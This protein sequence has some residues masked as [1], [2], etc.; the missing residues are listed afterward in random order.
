MCNIK[1]PSR[2]GCRGGV[3]K[4]RVITT[5][6]G[7]RPPPRCLHR[8]P[9]TIHTVNTIDRTNNS[10]ITVALINAQSCRNKIEDINDLLTDNNFDVLFIV[11]SWLSER[12]DDATIRALTPGGYEIK[13]FPRKGRRGGGIAVL[14]KASLEN[15]IAFKPNVNTY[16]TFEH[17]ETTIKGNEKTTSLCTIYRPPPSNKNKLKTSEFLNDFEDFILRSD[18][19][20][21]QLIILGDFNIHIETDNP[22]ARQVKQLLTEHNMEQH[23][24]SS[25]HKAGHIIDWVITNSDTKLLS[26]VYV[27]DKCISDH[28]LVYFDI[29]V[30]NL[31]LKP[32]KRVVNS[33]NL[34]SI[35]IDNFKTDLSDALSDPDI[36]P[37][38]YNKT[39]TTVL[40]KHAPV[41]ERS[42]KERKQ[43][44][45]FN[46]E[47]KIAKQKKRR[48][49]MKWRKS[50]LSIDKESYIDCK[51][52]LK[53]VTSRSKANYY[54]NKF[55]EV[56]TS[57][58]FYRLSKDILGKEKKRNLPSASSDEELA[59][60]FSQFFVS[61]IRTIREHLNAHEESPCE[62][63]T[64]QGDVLHAFDEITPE[65]IKEI[66]NS[67]PNKSCI[68][69]PLETSL[70]KTCLD[71]VS[72]CITDIINVSIRTGTVPDV[73]KTAI[74]TPLLKKPGLCADD[75]Q[76]YR[77]VS[78]LPFISKI[79]EK[80]ILKQVSRHLEK[81]NLYIDLQSAYRKGHSTETA[82]V[83]IINDLL[84]V[85]DKGGTSALALLDLSAAFDTVDHNLLVRRLHES[86]GISGSALSWFQS[87]LSHRKQMVRIGSATSAPCD[88]SFGVPQGSVLG[89]VLFTLYTCPV[90]EIIIGHSLTPHMYA[91]DTQIY[92]TNSYPDMPSMVAVF[93]DCV[94]EIGTWMGQNRLQLNSGKTEVLAV[95]SCRNM[96][97]M[98]D[99]ELNINGSNVPFVDKAKN[100]GV[101]IDS[102]LSMDDQVSALRSKLIAD[103]R[104]I[105]SIRPLLTREACKKLVVSIMLSKLDY[106]NSLLFNT[107]QSN[108]RRLQSIQNCAARM[109]FGKNRQTDATTLLVQLHWLP[110]HRRIEYK[111]AALVH[112]ALFN[113]SAPTYLSSLIS[114][115]KPIRSLRSSEKHLLSVP[116]TK[117]KVGEKCFSVFGPKTWNSLPQSIRD[118]QSTQAFRRQLKTFMFRKFLED[119]L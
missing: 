97:T 7:H 6:I 34:K 94:A 8:P 56:K 73:F 31:R 54:Q 17:I 24:N 108:I 88:L 4:E 109:I 61:K 107:K 77:P 9:P 113:K 36:A 66:I 59:N 37:D 45:W 52:A 28:K 44:P 99:L 39:I 67:S 93:E 102:Q 100:L 96:D 68:L 58:D 82:L 55:I 5:Q 40:D 60:R 30:Q 69:D 65:E 29:A 118:I 76:N 16:R 79:L 32:T 119:G 11:E 71:E 98:S 101:T 103:L 64:F 62:A 75:L 90:P 18:L 51:R 26:K 92:N 10:T 49:E 33:R 13:S 63:T 78:N 106:C 50:G 21:K 57:K 48:A 86:F 87:Y 25:T 2:R 117:L 23:V 104:T 20:N 72:P 3:R 41:T 47:M 89:P 43:C 105:N 110:V 115:Y 14:Y 95:C 114:P 46:C 12:G 80:V 1:W 22:E 15:A 112:H 74:V 84:L 81:N 53:R 38:Y 42:V 116:T 35:D 91:D 83:R 27:V 19:N 111:A 70:L 85:L